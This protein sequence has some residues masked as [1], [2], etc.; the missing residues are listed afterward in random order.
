MEKPER[1]IVGGRSEMWSRRIDGKGRGG[2][3]RKE[4]TST[5]MVAGAGGRIEKTTIGESKGSSRASDGEVSVQGAAV[6]GVRTE[7]DGDI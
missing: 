5:G 7:R 6:H 1:G 2:S 4:V 3:R